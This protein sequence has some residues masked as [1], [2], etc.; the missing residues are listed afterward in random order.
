MK[1]GPIFDEAGGAANAKVNQV[2]KNNYT[3][4]LPLD[5]RKVSIGPTQVALLPKLMNGK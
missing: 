4:F 1:L 2:S 5:R 3:S